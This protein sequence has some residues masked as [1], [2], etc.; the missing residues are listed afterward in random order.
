MMQQ[1]QNDTADRVAT[2]MRPPHYVANYKAG[3]PTPPTIAYSGP[4]GPKEFVK[5]NTPLTRQHQG[6]ISANPRIPTP[7]ELRLRAPGDA[8]WQPSKQTTADLDIHWQL[9]RPNTVLAGDI[10]SVALVGKSMTTNRPVSVPAQ[11]I[12]TEQ[13][14]HESEVQ[15][16][17]PMMETASA[18]SAAHN[19]IDDFLET[20][21]ITQEVVEKTN[22][23]K[24][25]S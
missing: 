1:R 12:D 10:S 13:E 8:N 20:D 14:T 7:G 5:I 9:D 16:T 17:I 22:L 21:S 2:P 18:S 25:P 11:Q 3:S 19:S 23:I 4:D 15:I 24:I 6:G